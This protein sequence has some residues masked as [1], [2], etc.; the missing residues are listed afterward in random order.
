MITDIDKYVDFL[1]ANEISEH[2]FLILWLVQNKDINNIKKYKLKF[3]QFNVEEILDLIDRGFIDD[4][5]VV[6][7]KQEFDIFNFLVTDKFSKLVTIDYQ[8]AYDNLVMVYPKWVTVQGRKYPTITGD[9]LKLSKEYLKYHK[10]NRL[11]T[12]RVERITKEYFANPNAVVTN[13][14]KYILNRL[15]NIYEEEIVNNPK[16]NP[17]TTL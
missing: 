11:A 16:S 5:G 7:D 13:I 12:E 6:R 4:F 3:K 2:Q 14:E 1:T 15:W 10:N 9:P 8:D 17:F